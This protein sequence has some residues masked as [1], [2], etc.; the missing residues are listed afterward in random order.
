[1]KAEEIL[2]EGLMYKGYPCTK[3]C[4]GHM[5]GYAWA[6]QRNIV[7]P[8]DLP[9]D[10]NNSFR[11]GMLSFTEGKQM[12]ISDIIKENSDSGTTSSGSVATVSTTLGNPITRDSFSN[13]KQKEK[14]GNSA[15]MAKYVPIT[16]E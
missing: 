6:K 14:Y 11:E 7:N 8:Q 9:T 4:S 16:K 12:K 10:T 2:K 1:M 15:K 5:A 13:K 3:D